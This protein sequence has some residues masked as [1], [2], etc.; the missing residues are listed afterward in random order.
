MRKEEAPVG[1]ALS[2]VQSLDPR[3]FAALGYLPGMFF[4]PLLTGRSD[5]TQRFHAAQ[6]LAMFALLCA[7]GFASWGLE[8]V[9]GRILARMVIVGFFFRALAWLVRYP[10]GIA[11]ALAYI[12]GIAAG[13]AY[14][15]AGTLRSLPVIGRFVPRISGLLRMF[16][17][18][19]QG[20]SEEL[21][22]KE[23]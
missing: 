23:V 14:A 19:V 21:N 4:L 10:V 16:V 7:A 20:R 3:I 12:S 11:L 2:V 6:S 5:E 9:F 1:E 15:A 13:M 22:S 18:E 8:I 17:N